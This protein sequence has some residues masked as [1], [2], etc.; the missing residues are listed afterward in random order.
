MSRLGGFET[1]PAYPELLQNFHV[2]LDTIAT[3]L[4]FYVQEHGVPPEPDTA[5]L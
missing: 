4:A 3:G 5:N 1:I 2:D